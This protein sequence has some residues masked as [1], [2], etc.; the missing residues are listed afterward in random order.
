MVAHSF[1]AGAV[2][3]GIDSTVMAMN[4]IAVCSQCS[5]GNTVH[6]QCGQT[7]KTGLVFDPA[8]FTLSLFN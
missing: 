3:L 8:Q 2:K 1:A 4:Y 7:I 5:Q 6:P